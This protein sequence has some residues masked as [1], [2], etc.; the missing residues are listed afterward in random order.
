ME[1]LH[2]QML[3]EFVISTRSVQISDRDNR[4]RKLWILLAYLIYHRRRAVAQDELIRLLWSEEEGRNPAGALK[5]IL[6]R[7]RS[8]LDRLWPEAGR[9]LIRY[10]NGR[11]SWNVEVSVTVDIDRFDRLGRAVGSG[12]VSDSQEYEDLLL[13]KG[14]FLSRLSAETWVIPIA[15]Y[16]H[17]CYMGC[18]LRLLPQLLLQ[19]KW[20]EAAQLC[21]VA[22]GVE[23]YDEN[24]H[25]Y[26]MKSLLGMEDQKGAAKIFEQFSERLYSDFGIN[27]SEEMRTLYYEAIRTDNGHAIPIEIIL[28]QLQEEEEKMGA[29]ICEYDFFRV[30]YRAAARSMPRSGMVAHIALLSVE[31]GTEEGLTRR[32]LQGAMNMLEEQIRISLRRGDTAARCSNSQYILLLPQANYENSCMVCERIIKSYYRRHPH[33]DAEIRYAVYPLQPDCGF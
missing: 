23:P 33:S 27:P 31:S 30:L 3:G 9:Q 19:E 1:D 24:I 18:L 29:L 11:Y 12:N 21:R 2:V 22:S 20:N 6:H 25:C 15:A 14:D 10:Q 32:K 16:Y 8:M 5:T 7:V 28:Q 17:N 13:Y 26:F 4:S